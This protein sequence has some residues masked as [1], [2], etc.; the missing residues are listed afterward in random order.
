[1]RKL[2]VPSSGRYTFRV[3]MMVSFHLIFRGGRER[4][5]ASEFWGQLALLRISA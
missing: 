4:R 5:L 3:P 2:N 1:M